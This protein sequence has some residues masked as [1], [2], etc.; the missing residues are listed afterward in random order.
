MYERQ[1]ESL[2]CLARSYPAVLIA[3]PQQVGKTTI[4]KEVFG[5][6]PYISLADAFVWD[7][8]RLDPKSFFTHYDDG[9][10]FDDIQHVS[11]LLTYL[12]V[13]IDAKH[14]NGRFVLIGS[15]NF[16]MNEQIPEYLAGHVDILTLLPLSIAE[17]QSEKMTI[18]ELIISGGY[19]RLHTE[20]RENVWKFYSLYIQKYLEQNVRQYHNVDNLDLFLDFMRLC[21]KHV[22]QSLDIVNLSHDLGVDMATVQK[23]IFILTTSH[24]IFLLQPYRPYYCNFNNFVDL[25]PKIYFCDTGILSH[26][27]NIKLAKE[28]E[29][30]FAKDKFYKNIAILEEIKGRQL[31][32]PPNVYFWQD[33]AGH[34]VDCVSRRGSQLQAFKI[35]A[36]ATMQKE[37]FQDLDCFQVLEPSV[38]GCLIYGDDTFTVFSKT[39]AVC[40]VF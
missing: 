7:Q 2:R 14:Q 13:A 30:H 9:A 3:G 32:M 28:I 33:Q 35:E 4:A 39:E 6:L 11:E 22:G 8:A 12:Q 29:T 34:E 24:I 38:N 19:P 21:A 18:P 37:M 26:L 15:Q 20:K 36:K 5:Y 23:W 10:I 40:P 27:L 16:E 1:K 25:P 31:D 17:L